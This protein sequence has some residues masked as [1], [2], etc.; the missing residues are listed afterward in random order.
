MRPIITLVTLITACLLPL[1]AQATTPVGTGIAA[2]MAAPAAPQLNSHA[3]ARDDSPT[4][5]TPITS[6]PTGPATVSVK[7]TDYGKVLAEGSGDYAGCSLY[8]LTSNELH[9]LT[10]G[11][12]PFA[13]SDNPT[14]IG[15]A[16]DSVLWPALLTKGRPVAGLGVNRALLGT[17]TRSDVLPGKSV[18]QVTYGGLPLYRFF[19]DEKPG[20]TDGAN[21]FDPVT[22][23]TG[24]WY[25][26]KPGRGLPATGRAHLQLET[27]GN[28]N[29]LSVSMDDDFSLLPHGSFPVYTL[30]TGGGYKSA[31]HGMC[32]LNWQPVLTSGRPEAGASVSQHALGMIV[33]HDGTHQVTYNGKPLY[34]FIKDAYIPTVTGT[35]SINGSGAVTRWGVFNTISL[36]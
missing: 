34:L 7:S 26:V 3:I 22:S 1:A 8:I 28:A 23:P 29:V 19:L 9:A 14:V 31:C 33:R 13:C 21:L 32:A 30:R 25:L 2:A 17:V 27:V 5:V 16:C 35:Q 6:A 12:A 20:E 10:Y 36:P 11:L 15:P 4:C 24:T 18:K